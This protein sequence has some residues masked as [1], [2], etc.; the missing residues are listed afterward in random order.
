MFAEINVLMRILHCIPSIDASYGGPVQVVRAYLNHLKQAGFA[1]SIMT[2]SSSNEAQDRE[3]AARTGCDSVLWLRPHIPRFYIDFLAGRF[4]PQFDNFELIHVHGVFNG[5]SSAACKIARSRRRPYVLTPFGTLSPVCLSKN[6]LL[7]ELALVMGESA[8]LHSAAAV[9]FTSE[10]E[11]ERALKRFSK[12]SHAFVLPNGV[13]WKR[14]QDLP[15]P[16][17]FR[18]RAGISAEARILLFV[19][20]V[21]PIKGLDALIPAFFRWQKTQKKE[22]RLVIAG[23]FASGYRDLLLKTA[24]TNVENKNMLFTGPLYDQD[25]LQAFVDS[26]LVALPSYHENFGLSALEGMACGK[27]ILI[28]ERA[29]LSSDVLQ[30]HF[31]AVAEPTAGSLFTALESLTSEETEWQ[32]MGQRARSWVRDRYDW[33]NIVGRLIL[34]YERLLR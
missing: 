25:L 5:L 14:F 31:G 28:S 23:P 27:P 3:N 4:A 29:D 12:L 20:R 1:V 15:A 18:Q 26:D 22:W 13:E 8:N 11:R 10:G 6:R 30:N 2:M 17:G 21:D 19:G 9:Q 34:E 7:K 16:G 32:G 24:G 33:K